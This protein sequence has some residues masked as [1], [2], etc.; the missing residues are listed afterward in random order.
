VTK[1][2]IANAD[3]LALRLLSASMRARGY[4]TVTAGSGARAIIAAVSQQPDMVILDLREVPQNAVHVIEA[5]RS[6]AQMPILVISGR[7]SPADTVEALDAG[8]DDYLTR[9]FAVAEL[10]ARVRALARRPVASCDRPAVS[11][12]RVRV[13]LAAKKVGKFPSDEHIGRSAPIR[14][15]PTEWRILELLIANAGTLVSRERLL[16]QIWGTYPGQ[17]TSCL[18]VYVAQLR[19]KLE[20]VPSVPRFLITVPGIGYR[21]DPD[22]IEDHKLAGSAARSIADDVPL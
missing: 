14:L 8:A 3:P 22:T 11:F 2:L 18:R 13:D 20:P 6:R 19:R 15:S 21:F 16:T 12:G 9:P 4:D 17:D 1:V 5:I 7:A 10:Q